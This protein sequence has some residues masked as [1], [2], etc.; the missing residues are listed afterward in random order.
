MP[1]TPHESPRAHDP[2]EHASGTMRAAREKG[3]ESAGH[4]DVMD[5]R[6]V[7]ADRLAALGTL[8][9]GVA[10]EIN[11][12]L[13]YVL[14][15]LEHVIRQLRA[16]VASGDV[17]GEEVL[18]ANVT[19]LVQ[20]LEG[21]TRVR[22]IVRDLMTFS[23]GHLDAKTLIDVRRVVEAS[24]QVTSHELRHRARIEKRL[25]E[26]PPVVGNEAR[27]GQVL[28][29]VLVNA[30]HAIPEGDA[31]S[32]TVTVE[33]D[34]GEEGS[35]VIVVADTGDGIAAEDL[36]R[37][38]DPFFT[39]RSAGGAT[40]LGL[41]IAHGIVASLGGEMTATSV[42]GHGTR[43]RIALPMAPGYAVEARRAPTFTAASTVRRRILVIDDEVRVADAI[44][45]SLAD[46]H[47]VEVTTDAKEALARLVR[48]E[49]YDLV[50]CDLMMPDMTGM[51]FYREVLRSVP[52]MAPRI[53]FMSGG[54]Y[55]PR[56]REFV[57]AL[58]NRCIEKPPEAAKLRELAR[59]RGA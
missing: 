26:V 1:R 22:G 11:N 36:P 5:E 12:P 57:E 29:N 38:F 55:T 3:R 8:A 18:E 40:G 56:A 33:T 52:P 59:H 21:A 50:L 16:H 20:A 35:V 32:N 46:E 43:F 58:P 47:D 37:I 24:L 2:H 49:R 14:V 41:S 45:K 48:G 54:V 25:R 28:L 15:N 13:T 30:A 44:A 17:L 53:V 6:L 39:T 31:A 42:L 19:A 23:H 10:H 4:P 9:A 27:L 51:D 34:V 7:R